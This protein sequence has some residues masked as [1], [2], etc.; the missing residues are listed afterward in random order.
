MS[1]LTRL[2]GSGETVNK[3]VDAVVDG[4]DAMFFTEEE[5]SRANAEILQLKI[6]W[7]KATTGSRL[8]RRVLAFMF[9]GAFLLL[10]LAAAAFGIWGTQEDSKFLLNLAEN[11]LAIPVSVILGF[12]FATQLVRN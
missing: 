3:A 1:F 7:A 4:V 11:T 10:I 9:S 2:F 8:A 5:K 6:E 12:Y